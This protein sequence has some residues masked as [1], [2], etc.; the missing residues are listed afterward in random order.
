MVVGGQCPAS[1]LRGDACADVHGLVL[2]TA[3]FRFVYR[4]VGGRVAVSQA[5][6]LPYADGGREGQPRFPG[7]PLRVSPIIVQAKVYVECAFPRFMFYGG[8]FLRLAL[9]GFSQDDSDVVSYG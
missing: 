3:V 1:G 9:R 7:P 4:L 2:R 6:L 8:S 5:V